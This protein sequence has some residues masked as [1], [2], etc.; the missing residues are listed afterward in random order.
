VSA[1]LAREAERDP[2]VR[3]AL[4]RALRVLD[5]AQTGELDPIPRD[6]AGSQIARDRE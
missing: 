2:K 5:G 1:D 3:D 4:D 6:F